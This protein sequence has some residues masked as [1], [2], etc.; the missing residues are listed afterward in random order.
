MSRDVGDA[1][2]AI[3]DTVAAKIAE[4]VGTSRGEATTWVF[5]EELIQAF[6]T[7]ARVRRLVTSGALTGSIVGRR[8]IVS[9][10]AF[11]V[12]IAAH[13]VVRDVAPANDG[14]PSFDD[15]LKRNGLRVVSE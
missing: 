8:I 15:I 1:V 3:L 6:G 7:R 10:A 2:N 13:V 9:R 4:R 5:E 12:F 14:E 11:D